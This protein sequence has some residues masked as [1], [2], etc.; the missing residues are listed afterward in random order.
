MTSPDGITWTSRTSAADSVWSSVTYGNGLFVA[1]A[2]GVSAS[3]CDTSSGSRIMTSPDGIT[4]TSRTSQTTNSWQSVVY[5]NGL[6][7][8]VANSGSGDRVMTSPDGVNW[9]IGASAANNNWY[10]VTYGNGRFVAVSNSGTGNRVMTS[11]NPTASS[12][13]SQISITVVA[14]PDTDVS[15]TTILQSTSAITDTPVEGV[16]YATGTA[17]GASTVA[18]SLSITASSTKVCNITSL[19]NGTS[20][21]FKVF[22]Q[23]TTGN[24]STG[25]DVGPVAPGTVGVTLG[26]GTDT[27]SVILPP[28]GTATTSD[29]FTFQTTSGT[30]VIPSLTV[31]FATGTAQALSLVEIT[32]DAGS[33]VY[34]SAS[35]PSS[36]TVPITL[37]T[38]TLTAN[39]TQTQYRVRITPKTHTNM[40]SVPGSTYYVTSYVSSFTTTSAYNTGTDLGG[41][42]TTMVTVDNN[43]PDT[44]TSAG[45]AWTSRLSAS[46][47][48]WVSVTYG[49]GLFV[50]V[51]GTTTNKNVM[52]SPDGITWTLRTGTTTNSWQSVTYGNGLFV[53]VS[54]SGTGNRVMTSP[55]GITWTSRTSAADNFW[56]SVT[57]GNGLFVAVSIS[58]TGNR[59]MTSPDGITWTSRTAPA[60]NVWISV[61]YGNGLFVAV[62]CGVS[63]SGS[64]NSTSGNNRVMS[65]ISCSPFGVV[66]ISFTNDD[67]FIPIKLLD[68]LL[69]FFLFRYTFNEAFLP[70]CFLV[71]FLAVSFL[72]HRTAS[73]KSSSCSLM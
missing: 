9:T 62:A 23:D 22:T 43:S 34:G 48:N 18:C 57:Y 35:N 47:N 41:G 14:P 1:V 28:G 51:S 71:F 40:P 37:S 64:C 6:F 65:P 31:S 3:V 52:T 58:G 15:T 32:N 44:V 8:A 38:N 13:N 19:T 66:Q 17:I 50:A 25:V 36:D 69:C 5:G 73:L 59:I 11:S 61:T 53:A 2:C 24:F 27:P 72:F 4:W 7:V 54:I 68:L 26:V 67:V 30:D 39:T 20:Y 12:S 21:Y 46:N 42:T 10:G 33:T 49:N 55:D 63:A 45:T 16:Y 70:A 29:T 56:Y 60:E